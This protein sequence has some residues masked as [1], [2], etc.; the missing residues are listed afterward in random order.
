MKSP[1]QNDPSS[2][3][4]FLVIDTESVPDGKL[5]GLVKYPDEMLTPEKAI[6]KARQEAIENSYNGSDFL[7]VTFQI[8]VSVC[9][10]RVGEDFSLQS[11]RCIDAPRFRTREI[12]KLFWAGIDKYKGAR[13][14]TFNGRGFDLPLLEL[15]AFRYGLSMPMYYKKRNRYTG[16][17]ID[18]MDWITNFGAYRFPG[19]LDLLAKL[20]GKPGK[21][22]GIAG[23]RVYEFYQ[24][25]EFQ[26][27]ND[28]CMWDTLDTYFVFLRSRVMTGDIKLEE[29]SE[30]IGRAKDLLARQIPENPAL[31]EYLA[32]WREQPGWP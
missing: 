8:P 13:L 9:V 25:E 3:T 16:G 11:V 17:D 5:I 24:N 10:A 31:G 29:E 27:I 23:H 32:N 20:L 14:V 22:G 6:E 21:M 15:A 12:V 18:L 19:G 1:T 2:E 28:Y 30:L 4:S 7:P 26:K